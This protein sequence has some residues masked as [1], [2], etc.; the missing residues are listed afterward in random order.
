MGNAA[1]ES[2]SQAVENVKLCP[3]RISGSRGLSGMFVRGATKHI[4]DGRTVFLAYSHPL[5]R[6]RDR[7]HRHVNVK[8]F[9]K[10]R[11]QLRE[12]N[13]WPSLNAVAEVLR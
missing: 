12:R 2:A 1:R 4:D 9:A 13:V 8:H 7:L 6:T 10:G 3:G 5:K 11:L